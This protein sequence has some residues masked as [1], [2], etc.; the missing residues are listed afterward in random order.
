MRILVLAENAAVFFQHSHNEEMT[1]ID[2]HRLPNGIQIRKE[3]VGN[4]MTNHSRKNTMLDFGF[5]QI[6][7][8]DDLTVS[9][10]CI[11]CCNPED[12]R[13]LNRF[14]TRGDRNRNIHIVKSRYQRKATY[15]LAQN[16]TLPNR[17]H[18]VRCKILPSQCSQEF[19][20][21]RD[22]SKTIDAKRVAARLR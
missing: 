13:I 2:V 11:V 18:V 22:D 15:L 21:A 12:L 7:P 16:A 9:H 10:L 8:V 19:F 5:S 3:S 4:L 17:F 6:P 14:T 1:P 20:P